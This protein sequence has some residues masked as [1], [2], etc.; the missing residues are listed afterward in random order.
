MK[1]T[2]PIILQLAI[3]NAAE[4]AYANEVFDPGMEEFIVG[5]GLEFE[6][7]EEWIESKISYWT[8]SVKEKFKMFNQAEE[9]DIDNTAIVVSQLFYKL[10][11]G[12][13]K[14]LNKDVSIT[15]VP[16]GWIWASDK[17]PNPGTF[18]PYNDEFIAIVK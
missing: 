13:T 5:T 7:K 12:S 18:I 2:N 3:T 15:R 10:T 16:G 9:S 6:T 1:I 14:K 8:N 4:E 11:L 17:D